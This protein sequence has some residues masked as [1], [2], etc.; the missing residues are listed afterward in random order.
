MI[1]SEK[2]QYHV[3][4]TLDFHDCFAEFISKIG[5]TEGWKE[6]RL[7]FGDF[8]K[9]CTK[10][11]ESFCIGDAGSPL[12]VDGTLIGIA[13]GSTNCT[14]D[15]PDVYTNVHAYSEWIRSELKTSLD[16]Y[17]SFSEFVY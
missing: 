8:N 11:G 4:E 1:P 10:S 2:L 13:S 3:S 6:I 15:L 16:S 7:R 5:K 17:E 14:E 12:V 9:F